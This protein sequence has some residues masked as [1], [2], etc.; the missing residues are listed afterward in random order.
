MCPPDSPAKA[1]VDTR[2]KLC[3]AHYQ[4]LHRDET[5]LVVSRLKITDKQR[6]AIWQKL[7]A[8]GGEAKNVGLFGWFD[9]LLFRDLIDPILPY[10]APNRDVE[11]EVERLH[12]VAIY[13]K[14]GQYFTSLERETYFD[15]LEDAR[16]FV[17]AQ[18]V[19]STG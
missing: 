5:K 14:C 8:A 12:G 9:Y 11:V 17:I 13:Y 4:K 18:T 2:R 3:S 19:S 10:P 16:A 7:H 15:D 1:L 6:L